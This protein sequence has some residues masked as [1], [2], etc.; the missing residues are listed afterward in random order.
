MI[1][2]RDTPEVSIYAGLSAVSYSKSQ[3]TAWR[4]CWAAAGL[5]QKY[6]ADFSR[7][8]HA[9]LPHHH[10]RKFEP[11]AGAFKCLMRCLTAQA[12]ALCGLGLRQSVHQH[13]PRALLCCARVQVQQLGQG[14]ELGGGHDSS[15]H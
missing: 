13:K 2:R 11:T 10:P 12:G 1:R 7:S 4:F 3:N 15:P 8:K 5:F 9:Q 6:Q 14:G